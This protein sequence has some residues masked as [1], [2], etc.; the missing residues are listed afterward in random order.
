MEVLMLLS[1]ARA[2]RL[3]VRAAEGGRLVIRGPA[4]AAPL[5][6]Q[7]GAHK[8]AVLRALAAHATAVRW[9]YA[10]FCAR[11]PARGPIWPIRL[12]DGPECDEM[13]RCSMCGE[14]L[15]GDPPPRFPRCAACVEALTFA[16]LTVREGVT[17]PAILE[18]KH[19]QESEE[20]EKHAV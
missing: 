9:R 20:R 8:R 12:H 17:P 2:A 4:T 13:G 16:L 3:D 19:E 10:L 6:A 18:A 11:L 15:T 14:P 5:A 1:Q 7:L